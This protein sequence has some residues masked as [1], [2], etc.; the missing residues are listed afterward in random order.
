MA[1]AVNGEKD[2]IE[3]PCVARSGTPPSELIGIGLAEF[4]TPLAD[5][6]RGDHDAARAQEFSPIA[7]AQTKAARE[8]DGMAD[9]LGWKSV[10]FIGG[11]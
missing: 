11:A 7:V 2:L 9:D 8:P 1:F 3:V 5:R 6:L 4:P 10:I